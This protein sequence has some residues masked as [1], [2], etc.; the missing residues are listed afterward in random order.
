[1]DENPRYLNRLFSTKIITHR[2]GDKQVATRPKNPD[3]F[4]LYVN[5]PKTP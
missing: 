2:T 3:S 1:M 5:K 4:L